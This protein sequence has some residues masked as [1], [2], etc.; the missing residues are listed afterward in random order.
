[1]TTGANASLSFIPHGNP[2]D[3][4]KTPSSL[5]GDGYNR[6]SSVGRCVKERNRAPS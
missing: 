6:V 5:R 2:S 4:N 1:M 3:G